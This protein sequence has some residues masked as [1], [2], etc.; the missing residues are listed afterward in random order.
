MADVTG[1]QLPGVGVRYEFTT[2]GGE[3]IAVLLHRSG[4]REIAVYASDDPDRSTTVLHLDDDDSRTLADVLGANQVTE[5]LNSVQQPVA[6]LVLDWVPVS[7]GAAGAGATIGA[8]DFRSRTGASIVAVVRGDTTI[9]APGPDQVLEP[10]DVAVAVGTVDG[11]AK[12][13]ALL[14]P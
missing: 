9:A 13:R 11:L 5:A 1:T 12:L 2:S 4:R 3:R 6:G 8:G 10:G 7:S 14:G